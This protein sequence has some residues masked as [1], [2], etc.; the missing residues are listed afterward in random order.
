VIPFVWLLSFNAAIGG[1]LFGYDTGSASAALLEMKLPREDGGLAESGLSN[2]QQETL[3]SM[4][5]CGAF[6]SAASAGWLNHCLG[7][8][9]VILSG[10]FVFVVGAIGMA[11]AQTFATMLVARFVVGLGV[12]F[13]SHSVPLY[14]SECSPATARGRLCFLNDMCVVL[15]QVSAAAVSAGFFYAEVRECWR[16]ILGLA[17][18]PSVM[19]F[20]GFFAMPESPRWLAMKGQEV[21]CRAVLKRLR[22]EWSEKE[23][24]QEMQD[25]LEEVALQQGSK[26]PGLSK[27]FLDPSIRRPLLLGCGLQLVQQWVGINTIVYYGGSILQKA[28][29]ISD[30]LNPFSADNKFNVALTIPINAAQLVGVLLSW[31]LVDRVGRRPLLLVSLAGLTSALFAMGVVYSLTSVPKVAVVVVMM[32]YL[33]TFGV[34][35]SP[36][37]WTINAEIHPAAVR[38]KAISFATSTNWLMNWIVSETFLSLSVALSTNQAAPEDHPNGVFWLYGAVGVVGLVVFAFKLPETKG[39]TL[40]EISEIFRCAGDRG[41]P[42]QSAVA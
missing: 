4:V 39:M 17:S 19:M 10:A 1:F 20:F 32:L 12:G 35:M 25:I 2:W 3:V 22:Q 38:A 16:W 7:R 29:S 11:A 21:E 28:N 36:I 26:G 14:V 9:Y 34:G 8:R 15:G 40:E 33:I 5:V 30:D 6:F 23:V 13:C 42:E 27:Y 41:E 31:Y 18:I 24:E 37:P